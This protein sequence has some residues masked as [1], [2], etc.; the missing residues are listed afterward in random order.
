MCAVGAVGGGAVIVSP[1][2]SVATQTRVL[3]YSSRRALAK[4]GLTLGW[5]RLETRL[6]CNIE[7]AENPLM[8]HHLGTIG[9]HFRLG[10]LL[11]S[12]KSLKQ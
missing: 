9:S 11:A 3:R 10:A 8:D 1:A 5:C 4:T 12:R 2:L 7:G 6:I